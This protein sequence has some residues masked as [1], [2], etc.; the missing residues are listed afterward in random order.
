MCW[1][2]SVKLDGVLERSLKNCHRGIEETRD[3]GNCSFKAV[4]SMIYAS[5]EHMVS[6]GFSSP[7]IKC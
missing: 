2:F 7:P 6:K 3:D 1:V 5:N 4:S